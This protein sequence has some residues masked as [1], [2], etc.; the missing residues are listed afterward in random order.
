MSRGFVFSTWNQQAFWRHG[1]GLP[2]TTSLWKDTLGP[3]QGERQRSWAHSGANN[4]ECERHRHKSFVKETLRF[5]VR[6]RHGLCGDRWSCRWKRAGRNPKPLWNSKEHL[7]GS[8]SNPPSEWVWCWALGHLA[9]T[10]CPRR[11]SNMLWMLEVM[12][13]KQHGCGSSWSYFSCS[14]FSCCGLVLLVQRFG[15]GE[16]SMRDS[17]TMNYSLHVVIPTCG[18]TE[19]TST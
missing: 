15:C 9:Q 1:G 3:K 10:Q 14:Y 11:S 8:Q 5:D 17:T 12:V 6:S 4:P 13:L 18:K 2:C 19:K 16:E 7:E